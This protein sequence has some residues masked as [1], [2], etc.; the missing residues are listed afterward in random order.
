MCLRLY[1]STP[2]QRFPLLNVETSQQAIYVFFKHFSDIC[3]IST[4]QLLDKLSPGQRFH[5]SIIKVNRGARVISATRHLNR[6]TF[7]YRNIMRSRS[8]VLMSAFLRGLPINRL[9]SSWLT[10]EYLNLHL[11]YQWDSDDVSSSIYNVTTL[12]SQVKHVCIMLKSST[13]WK[14]YV[15]Y[16]KASQSM[17]FWE[18]ISHCINYCWTFWFTMVCCEK[19][20]EKSSVPATE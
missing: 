5:S 8:I 13:R 10:N 15:L 17:Q 6:S 7:R 19:G 14:Q 11:V 16:L 20:V 4:S 2:N 9:I 1:I 18:L 3:D 12:F